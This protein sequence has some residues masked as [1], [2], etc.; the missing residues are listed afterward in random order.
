MEFPSIKGK[1]KNPKN[2]TKVV[3]KGPGIE[4][5]IPKDYKELLSGVFI[6]ATTISGDSGTRFNNIEKMK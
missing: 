6:T 5:K 2:I 3:M 1:A 4:V